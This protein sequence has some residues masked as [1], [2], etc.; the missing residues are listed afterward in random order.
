MQI[1]ARQAFVAVSAI[2]MVVLLIAVP[3]GAST[4]PLDTRFGLNSFITS[5]F[6]WLDWER[7]RQATQD[8][9]VS[10]LR[11][12][13]TW[14]YLEPE[15]GNWNFEFTDRSIQYADQTGAQIMGLLDYSAPWATAVPHDPH[16][17]KYMPDLTLWRTYVRTVVDRYADQVDAWQVW[18]EPNISIFFKPNPDPAAYAQLL[19]IA[20]EE[21]R[22]HDPDAQIVIA[23]TSR[24][25]MGFLDGVMAQGAGDDFDILAFHPY[26][27]SFAAA[28]E[29]MG[30]VTDMR[31]A[32]AMAQK[33]NKPVWI[34]EIGWPNHEGG[35][36][37]DQL[38][39]A[40]L[41]RTMLLGYPYDQIKKYFWYDLRDDGDNARYHEHRFGLMT[42][43]FA[44]KPAYTAYHQAI[45][46]LNQAQ[47]LETQSDGQDGLYDMVF[48]RGDEIVRVVWRMGETRMYS[49][50]A[51]RDVRVLDMYGDAERYRRD[52]ERIFVDIG[53]SPLYIISPKDQKMSAMRAESLSFAYVAQTDPPFITSGERALATLTIQNT[54]T[55]D[56]KREGAFTAELGTCR[57][58]D[59]ASIFYDQQTWLGNNRPAVML[60][61]AVA[62]GEYATFQFALNTQGVK[63]GAYRE[64]MCV[65]VRDVVWMS[66]VG[67]YWNIEVK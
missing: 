10:W 49:M 48:E 53:E 36:V 20:S 34:T 1:R 31:N 2:L 60:Q 63:T 6:D 47:Y 64:H 51:S 19:A 39:A 15:Q 62:P 40:Y 42:R 24:V 59:R 33:Y 4:Q 65:L 8:L 3:R 66:D 41:V 21:I 18:N 14:K 17:D 23:G 11:E 54:G 52:D 57:T 46:Q 16:A 26:P 27:V 43:D 9:G 58:S 5:R 56:W 13:F 67:I 22:S 35:P 45:R 28:P 37:S 32:Q 30:Y 38:Q 50:E 7:P 44:P 25:D 55:T 61:E 12:E 29:Q